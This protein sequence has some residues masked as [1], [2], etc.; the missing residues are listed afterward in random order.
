MSLAFCPILAEIVE[1]KETYGR[2]GKR[3]D[4]GSLSTTNNLLTLRELHLATKAKRTLEVGLAM[5]GSGLVFTQTHKDLDSSPQRQHVAIDPFQR[6]R[7]IDEAGLVAIEKAGLVDY[8][9]FKEAPSCL[10]LPELLKAGK[11]FD[12]VYIDGSH[13]FEDVFIDFDYTA[14]ILDAGGIVLFDDS[15]DP[16]VHNTLRFIRK[17]LP[18]SLRELDLSP[19]RRHQ[20]KFVYRVAC[21]IGKS[22]L[23]AFQKIAGPLREWNCSYRDF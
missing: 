5:G 7:W 22:Q 11:R 18:H 8:L 2:S 6:S 12:L 20:S 10:I 1:R 13:L 16:H 23:T 17:N 9:D 19:Y 3:L 14:R 15:V 21:A 4:L